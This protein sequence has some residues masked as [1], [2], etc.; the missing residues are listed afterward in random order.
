[1]LLCSFSELQSST[2]LSSYSGEF[3]DPKVR[4]IV[5]QRIATQRVCRTLNATYCLAV[6][7]LAMQSHCEPAL[8]NPGLEWY[9]HQP[10]K[11]TIKKEPG[12]CRQENRSRPAHP[13]LNFQIKENKQRNS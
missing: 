1:M 5:N 6:T 10:L 8:N 7:M 9:S 3:A 12:D 2:F 13:A 4:T 11:E